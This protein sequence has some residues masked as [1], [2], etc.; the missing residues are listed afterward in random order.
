LGVAYLK[1]GILLREAA[2]KTPILVMGGIIGSQVPL[3]L[4]YDLTLTA[5]SI[6]KLEQ[7]DKAANEMDVTA[8]VNLKID[9]GMERIG[10][11]YYNATGF[12]Q[13]AL[14]CRNVNIEG[15][16]FALCQC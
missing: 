16:F 1:E 14:R 9:T 11:H 15:I 10:V 3:F 8:K 12:L 7:I 5:S 2:I 4:K 13:A 6:E